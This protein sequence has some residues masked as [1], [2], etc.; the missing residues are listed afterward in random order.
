MTTDGQTYE[1]RIDL[2]N[3]AGTKGY[4]RYSNFS[5]AD[6]SDNYRLH[7]GAFL[8]GT[9]GKC[10]HTKFMICTQYTTDFFV[11]VNIFWWISPLL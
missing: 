2:I 8:G 3:K 5:I 9:A 7:V 11:D 4:A 6:S 10:S 1:L